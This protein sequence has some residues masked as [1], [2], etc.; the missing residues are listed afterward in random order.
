MAERL[1]DEL[2]PGTAPL[3]PDEELE[4]STNLLDEEDLTLTVDPPPAPLGKGPAYDFEN[5]RLVR[6]G[7]GIAM[8]RREGTLR[9]WIEKCIRTHAG[10]HPVHPPGYGL[11]IAIGDILGGT[12][13][14]SPGELEE[15]IQDALLFHPA[16]TEVRSFKIE[17]GTTGEG[18]GAL[19]VAFTVELDDGAEIGFETTVVES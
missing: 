3:D 8:T 10:A 14:V 6:A 7:R 12:A 19:S 5:R 4:Q 9:V 1:I 18:D 13:D 2:V 16:I 11:A 17:E 15:M